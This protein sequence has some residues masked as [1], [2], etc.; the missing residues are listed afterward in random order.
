MITA[1]LRFLGIKKKYGYNSD[2]SVFM[3]Q[4]S[5]RERKRVFLDA[6]RKA[7]EEQKKIVE[8]ASAH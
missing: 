2:F 6:A 8:K 5:A 3:R 4:A 7:T 1:A